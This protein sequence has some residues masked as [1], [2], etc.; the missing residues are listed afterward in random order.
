MCN[1]Q[2]PKE[3]Q[4]TICL[5][6][7]KYAHGLKQEESIHSHNFN[8]VIQLIKNQVKKLNTEKSPYNVEHQYNTISI[9]G[10]RGTGKTTFILSLLQ[11]IEEEYKNDAEILKIIDPTQ[12]EEKEHVF[13]VILS[14]ID[15]EVRRKIESH[16][17]DNNA[18]CCC[19][20]K[21][22]RNKLSSLAKGLPTLE[23][24]NKKQY[25]NWDD[26]LYIVERGLNNVKSAYDLESNFHELVD[27]ALDILGKKFFVLAFDDID[28]NMSKGWSVLE[29]IRKYLTTPK[30]VIF[31]SG[32][33]TLY[34]YNV[35]LHQWNQLKE[36][37]TFE[38]HDYKSQV[39]QL[40]GQ[41]LLKV[42]KP[43]NRIQL[44]TLLD[45]KHIYQTS[46]M[47]KEEAKEIVEVYSTILNNF[48]IHKNSTQQLF[49]DY[50]LGL[51]IRSQIS[52]LSDY[53]E[54]D[55]MSQINAYVSRMMV[56]DIDVDL[57]IKNPIFTI[58]SIVEYLK[59]SNGFPHS[60]LLIPN[61]INHDMN[62]VL[63]G[64]TTI[65][66]NQVK[67]S[68]WI[69]FDYMLRVG[70]TRNLN[71]QL[72]PTAFDQ[73]LSYT[74]ITQDMSIKNI[75]LLMTAVGKANNLKLPELILLEGLALKA[76]K[77]KKEKKNAIDIILKGDNISMTPKV[78][79]LLPLFS[80]G[81]GQHQKTELYYSV[82]PLLSTIC[83]II[84]LGKDA[85]S[86]K[87]LLSDLSLHRT[88]PMPSEGQIISDT[89][90]ENISSNE[91]LSEKLDINIEDES[92][93]RLVK[94]L[95]AWRESFIHDNENSPIPPYLLGRIMTR[96]T[97]ALINVPNKENLAELFQQHLIVFL[98]SVLIEEAKE[99]FGNNLNINNN[100]PV[101]SPQLFYDNLGK[102]TSKNED[103]KSYFDSLSLVRC[104]LSCPLISFFF[105]TKVSLEINKHVND[106]IINDMNLFNTLSKANFETKE[107]DVNGKIDIT[108]KNIK[109]SLKRIIDEKG[110]EFFRTNI[111][112]I[113]D[114]RKA[115]KVLKNL[116]FVNSIA[117]DCAR[118]LNNR[119]KRK[120]I[121]KQ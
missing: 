119:F 84:R 105:S 32:N 16:R 4:I 47:I 85:S 68:P 1:N 117:Q 22:W 62:G 65:F 23:G 21:E 41:Y 104:L 87:G 101:G 56:A 70:Y 94:A 57:A 10:G 106:I 96:F 82:L 55:I 80:L 43:E 2:N 45:Y 38:E 69:I 58:I 81:K 111:Y 90:E 83:M 108:K 46:Y 49:I 72:S 24:L 114:N 66:A 77:N 54:P 115:Y 107:N 120:Y 103:G 53:N 76:K 67:Q 116:P 33:L 12:M 61:T 28:V 98:N 44:R 35:R 74:G 73:I 86:I 19:F 93:K 37:K 6:D 59:K 8:R 7:S 78:L 26:D 18:S 42:L 75:V 14:L 89:A 20:E 3:S 13:L 36:L 121:D 27:I 95:I 25:E 102:V 29:T 48:G 110:V 11:S 79:A 88:Y 97:S 34:S 30:F 112:D 15:T 71:L 39:N 52:I 118:R 109:E 51:S 92:V 91:E 31:L 60:Y 100:N 5:E 40:E 63:M 17:K 99:I 64:L 113:E 50:L 9:F